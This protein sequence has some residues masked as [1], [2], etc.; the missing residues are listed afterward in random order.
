MAPNPHPTG[1]APFLKGGHFDQAG[2]VTG[3]MVLRGEKVPIDCF[4][5]RDR[6]WGPRPLGRPKR[7]GDGDR[8]AAATSGPSA[9]SATPSARPG[10]SE[11]WLTYAAP[12]PEAEPV[13]CGFL[14]RDGAYGHILAGERRVTSTPRR[15][16]AHLGDRGGRRFD[17]R[18]SVHGDAVSRHWRGH[19]GDSLFRWHWDDGVDGL[20]RGPELLQPATSGRPTGG[21]RPGA[22]LDVVRGDRGATV[23]LRCPPP[24]PRA[25]PF[26]APGPDSG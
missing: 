19:G 20:G 5:A 9:A 24:R 22:D 12:G 7:R 23:P 21:V 10:P 14:L 4:S 11:A 2:H 8:R 18:L 15:V 17:R 16:A 26:R 6:S 25:P 3:A 13:S 1:V